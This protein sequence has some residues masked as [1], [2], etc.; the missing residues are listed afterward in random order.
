MKTKH[1]SV[2]HSSKIQFPLYPTICDDDD[3]A[4]LPDLADTNLA[5]PVCTE[6]TL[7]AAQI[8]ADLADGVAVSGHDESLRLQ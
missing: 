8:L 4:F 3:D 6:R 1:F 5:T 7:S 2:V